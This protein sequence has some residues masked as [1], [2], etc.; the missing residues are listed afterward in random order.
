MAAAEVGAERSSWI[1]GV[2][3]ES[4]QGVRNV[5]GSHDE[6]QQLRQRK[7]LLNQQRKA[8]SKQLRNEERK[9]QRLKERAKKLSN[10]DLIR[11]LAE[12]ES[13]A[14]AKAKPHAKSR[15]SAGRP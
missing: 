9:R 3:G 5:M 15:V 14:K 2:G 4:E 7:V 13:L 10:E 1:E 6:I 8:L 12:R 11:V